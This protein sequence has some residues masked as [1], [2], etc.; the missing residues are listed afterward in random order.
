MSD[1]TKVK[2]HNEATISA[3]GKKRNTNAKPVFCIDTGMV[4]AS[5]LD[6]AEQIGVSPSTVSW[7]LTGRQRTCKGKRYCFVSQITEHLDEIAST[8]QVREFEAVEYRKIMYKH[9]AIEDATAK[10]EKHK[11]NLQKLK[12][13][14][15]A[16]EQAIIDAEKKLAEL[17]KEG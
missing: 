4:Y 13:K 9:Q 7:V 11:E 14:L 2:L 16:E 17:T 8:A 6:V 5:S 3:R 12:Q 15:Q 1:T 10:L